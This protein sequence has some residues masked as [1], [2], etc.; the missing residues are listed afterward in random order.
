MHILPEVDR[1]GT[2]WACAAVRLLLPYRHPWMRARVDLTAGTRLPS[3]NLHMV[4]LQRAG[5]PGFT[6]DD[7]ASLL[8]TARQRGLRIV[9]DLDDDLLTEHPVPAV[10]TNIAMQRPLIRLM[11]TA[12]DLVI[13]STDRLA[14]RVAKL[15][16]KVRVWENA[17]DDQILL[18]LPDR[19]STDDHIT[20]G[21]FGSFTHLPD[22]LHVR[23]VVEEGLAG[24]SV[25]VKL[26]ICGV[27]TNNFLRGLFH[28]I[29]DVTFRPPHGDYRTFMLR[30]QHDLHWDI[31]L[32][33]LTEHAFNYGKSDI[34][35]LDYAAFG[36]PGLYAAHPAYG[37]VTNGVTG[38]VAEHQNWS[39]SLQ[40][41]ATHRD[42]RDR[43]KRQARIYLLEERVLSRRLSALWEIV[44]SVV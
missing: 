6:L 5:P 13:V 19:Q 9:Y 33:P 15:N 41:L 22:L 36:V 1:D 25:S 44:Q 10:E 28:N 27:S 12:A 40:Q 17:I 39:A 42:V 20:I 32:A 14:N 35:F 16:P 26:E 30:M 2:E 24:L 37:H 29:S 8:R 7:A 23:Q 34:K 31:G 38:V 21:Y 43:I 4:I 3:D 18:D 11:L